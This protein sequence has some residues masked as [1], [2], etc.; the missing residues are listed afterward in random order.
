MATCI[1]CGGTRVIKTSDGIKCRDAQ[2]EG[3]K[4]VMQPTLVCDLCGEAMTYLGLNSW[5]EPNYKCQDCGATAK[6]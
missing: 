5:G 2:C 3:S 6:L 1:Y 4:T